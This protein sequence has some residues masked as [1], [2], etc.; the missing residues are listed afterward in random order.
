MSDR[1][2]GIALVLGAA[3]LWSLAGLG[4][5]LVTAG[6]LA[7][8]GIRSLFALPILVFAFRKSL[9]TAAAALRMPDIWAAAVS[10]AVCVLTFAA[11]TRLT[12]AANAIVLQYTG[13]AYVAL[14]SGPLL[15]ERLR[16]SDWIALIGCAIGLLVFAGD[17]IEAH[18]PLGIGFGLVSGAA[19]G[20][21]PV[22]LRRAQ[23]AG[24]PAEASVLAILVGNVIAVIVTLPFVLTA[25]PTDAVSWVSL[26]LLGVFQIGVAYLLY[27]AGLRHLRAVEASLSTTIEPVLNPMWVALG[28]GEVPGPYAV[29]GGLIIIAS[30]TA[31]GL[32]RARSRTIPA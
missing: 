26:A 3:L 6:P 21:L 11:A 31:Q 5:K 10:Y 13:P 30:I 28:T 17:G 27:A 16:R 1:T 25:P 18:G 29:F 2:R 4:I 19:F 7:I 15:G 8:G 22:F 20:S 9:P 24:A 23:R 32:A 12:T 14:L